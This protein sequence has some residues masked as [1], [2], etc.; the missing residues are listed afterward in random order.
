MYVYSIT[1]SREEDTNRDG[2]KDKLMLDI[3]IP[4]TDSEDVHRITVLTFFEYKLQVTAL[5]VLHVHLV[6]KFDP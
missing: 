2:K 3:E 4:I 5:S 1:Q 6:S